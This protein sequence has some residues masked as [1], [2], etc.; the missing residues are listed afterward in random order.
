MDDTVRDDISEL[1]QD[2]MAD[3]LVAD[4]IS[5]QLLDQLGAN[6]AAALA[7]SSGERMSVVLSRLGLISEQEI[8]L[9]SS[10]LLGRP[11]FSSE[12][13][14]SPTTLSGR[15]STS[16]LQKV[17]AVPIGP[18]DNVLYIA[19][20]D[21]SDTYTISS[22]ELLTGFKIAVCVGVLSEIDASI[23]SLI[24][25]EKPEE[26]VQQPTVVAT[27]DVS[28]LRDIASEAPVV[29]YVAQML[30]L[31]VARKASDIHL[32]SQK[33]DLRVRLRVDGH[34]IDLEPPASSM[35]AAIISRVKILAKLDIAEQ[36]LPQDGRMTETIRGEDIDFRVATA[37]SLFGERVVLRVLDRR[38]VPLE[39][40]KLGFSPELLKKY[41]AVLQQPH[42][43]LLVTGPTGSGKTTT[44]YA[45]LAHLNRP[46]LNILTVEDPVEY[47]M[48]GLTQVNVKPE[49]GL[50]F[51]NVLRAFLRQDPDIMMV[52]EIRDLETAKIA[53]Q[54][55]LTGHLVLAT[56][57]TND[58]ASAVTRLV[59]MG[60]EDYLLAATLN[61]VVAQRLVRTLCPDCSQ[62]TV[63]P[64]D[65]ISRFA[66]TNPP[67]ES[68]FR[69]PTGCQN[70]NGTG[71]LGRTSILELLPI[72]EQ[73]RQHLVT[74]TDAQSLSHLAI[75]AGMKPLAEAGLELASRGLTSLEEVLRVTKD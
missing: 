60:V 45:S 41:L 42:G 31:A 6:R 2:S 67:P 3:P 50:T 63:P 58:A 15:I 10:R 19:M 33:N 74:H 35:R 61:G 9:T 16:F 26:V 28:R 69:E 18:H 4:L 8:A 64:P 48:P 55:A 72:D 71:Y 22:L 1:K 13:L 65:V 32:E 12:N 62:E 54:A 44:L 68:N 47:E 73:F 51:A 70:C 46:E 7:R 75:S 57:H 53:V 37:P 29:R 21:P 27:E 59:E 38:R 40:D 34:L 17:H 20:A 56:L 23:L 14:S 39:F 36:R 30:E 24:E 52:G 11:L 25:S 43:I 66:R 5:R 49:I